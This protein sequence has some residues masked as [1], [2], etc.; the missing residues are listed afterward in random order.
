MPMVA[1]RLTDLRL[2]RRQALLGAGAGITAGWTTSRADS[3]AAQE[4]TPIV[5]GEP[6][7]AAS[8]A[9]ALADLEGRAQEAIATGA[10]PGM[11]VAVVYQGEVVFANGFGVRSVDAVDPVDA[12]TVFQLASVS[13]SLAATTVAAVVSDG[14]ATWDDSIVDHLPDF[15]L[16]DP[17]VTRNVTIRDC[18]CHRT[19]MNGT[20]G[21]DLDGIGFD[22]AEIIRRMRFLNLTGSFRQT[23]SYSNFGLTTG[24]NAA[25]AAAGAVWEDVAAAR[26]YAPLG[27]TATSSRFADFAS[28]DNRALLH[29]PV[30]G[31][32]QQRFTRQPDP[33]S[34]AGGVSSNATDMAQ[35]L[36]LVLGG[37]TVDGVEHIARAALVE[38]HSPQIMR[39]PNL[40]TGK[41][42]FYGL[43]W[44]VDFDEAGRLVW[45]H[46][47]AFSVGARTL[48]H[49]V[50]ELNLG[51]AVLANA[52][53]TG[54]PEGIAYTFF[55][56]AVNG[57]STRDWFALWNGA[58]DS[59]TQ[60]L[61]AGADA[62]ATPPA[63]PGAPLPADAYVGRYGNDYFGDLTVE[64]DG[65]ALTLAVGPGDVRYDV[66]HWDRDL[67]LF[68]PAAEFPGVM[69]AATFSINA[70]GNATHVLI[71]AL[72]GY[73]QGAFTRVS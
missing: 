10:V 28:R 62:Y 3:L 54:V 35:W 31:A 60:S 73:G 15:Q 9:A 49:L 46:A 47:G 21:D 18:F 65:D 72:D 67:F 2:S 33:Q 24:S 16:S 56:V 30:D 25:A 26:L 13:K 58:Y 20:A 12:D 69:S 37:G 41:P 11:A 48:V 57:T 36:R 43:G 29:V 61:T 19:G 55:D 71:E 45:G 32:W 53:P 17:W 42:S 23:Y 64:R 50:S 63:S 4:A 59:L 5:T 27:M 1:R 14:A 52:F 39:G 51:V 66:T 68:E 8:V 7:S 6:V 22:R 44:A 38:T 70:D 40:A 34:P